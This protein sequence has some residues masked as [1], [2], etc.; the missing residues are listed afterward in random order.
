MTEHLSIVSDSEPGHC[1]VCGEQAV[2]A[3]KIGGDRR[4]QCQMCHETWPYF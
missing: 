4:V 3:V 1:P 2:T